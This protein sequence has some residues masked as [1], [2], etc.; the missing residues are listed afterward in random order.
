MAAIHTHFP[1][2]SKF[3]PKAEGSSSG[4]GSTVA[5]LAALDTSALLAFLES[6]LTT[7]ESSRHLV[8]DASRTRWSEIYDSAETAIKELRKDH[9]QLA[10]ES[11]VPTNRL[12]PM[13]STKPRAFRAS[14]AEEKTLWVTAVSSLSLLGQILASGEGKVT[15]SGIWA[16]RK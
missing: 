2:A 10:E 4:I 9:P 1:A 7:A 13:A 16:K 15:A 14:A 8:A 6:G 5:G 12:R 11:P 3:Q